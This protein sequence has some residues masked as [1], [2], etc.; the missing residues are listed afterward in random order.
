MVKLYRAKLNIDES[1]KISYAGRL[2]PMARGVLVLLVGD[3]NKKRD[4]YQMFDKE[5]SFQMVLGMNTDTYDFLGMIENI[6]INNSHVLEN[7]DMD[8][9]YTRIQNLCQSFIGKINQPYPPY[10][11]FK[12]NGKSLFKWSNEGLLHTI[13]IPSKM[14]EIFELKLES[15]KLMPMGDFLNYVRINIGN[16]TSGEFRQER[17]LKQWEEFSLNPN[18]KDTNFPLLSFTSHVSHG[19]FIRSIANEMGKQLGTGAIAIDIYRTRVGPY[20]ISNIT[21]LD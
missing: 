12:V 5:Y 3:E 7:D 15:I 19:T 4:M 18:Y 13:E 21:S 8:G 11:S 20:S 14:V 16:I 2:D 17:I 10:S 9:I 1:I 6:S